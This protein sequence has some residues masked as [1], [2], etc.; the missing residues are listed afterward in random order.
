MFETQ[1]SCLSCQLHMDSA[2]YLFSAK[3]EK[4]KYYYMNQTQNI[5]LKDQEEISF[6]VIGDWGSGKDNQTEVNSFHSFYSQAKPCPSH[7][8]VCWLS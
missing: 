7:S 3:K 6:I 1:L 4:K 5:H 8:S 2:Q